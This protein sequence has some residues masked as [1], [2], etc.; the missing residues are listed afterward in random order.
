MAAKS[1]K[2]GDEVLLVNEAGG[3]I[4]LELLGL[5]VK[6][7]TRD[8]FELEYPLSAVVKVDPDLHHRVSDHHAQLV[9]ANDRM[10]ERI[11]R[12]KGKGANERNGG[13]AVGKRED[14]SRMEIDLHLHELIDDE[15]HLTDGEK[16]R[17]QL[18]YFERMLNT[19]IREKK[20]KLI[21]I[22]GVGEGVL[23]E[24]VR[25]VLQYYEGCRFDDADPR[26]YGYGATA[27]DI[28]HH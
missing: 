9:A 25:K 4:V 24:E 2:V 22:H 6:V 23:R 28:V 17:F 26:R 14:P 3:G 16:L 18:D 27:I 12:D 11:Q 1:L 8:G 15:R 7:R 20:R 21:V 13:K 10:Q 5:R 19:A